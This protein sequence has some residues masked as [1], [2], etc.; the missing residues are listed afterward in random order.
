M[1]QEDERPRS[2]SGTDKEMARKQSRPVEGRRPARPGG[3][4]APAGSRTTA[5]E[6]RNGGGRNASGGP[7][8]GGRGRPRSPSRPTTQRAAGGGRAPGGRRPPAFFLTWGTIALVVVV[9]LVL[10]VVK[11]TGSS[12]GPS[13]NPTAY[14]PLP[15]SVADAVTHVP[16]SVFDKVGVSAE[17]G[18]TAPTVAQGTTPLVLNGKPGVFYLGAEYC[19][20]CAAERWALTMALSRFGTFR[21]LGETRSSP[22]DVFPNTATMSYY[23]STYTSPYLAFRPVEQFSNVVDSSGNYAPLMPLSNAD[24]KLLAT[25][26]QPKYLPGV[27]PGSISYPFVDIGNKVFVTSASYSPSILQ[28]LSQQQIASAL[29]D[30]TNPVTQTIVSTAN[31]LTAAICAVDGGQPASVCT[32]KGVMAAA[33][34]LKLTP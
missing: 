25:Y 11:V 13:G 32:S 22:T 33:R 2:R 3:R 28:N 16:E 23:R 17:T 24:K 14:T 8:G 31:Y 15:A 5:G 10:V 26:Y 7:S 1:A 18:V 12:S 19:P 30:P 34:A 27:T 6:A 21:G 29:D 4:A 20:Y 9:V